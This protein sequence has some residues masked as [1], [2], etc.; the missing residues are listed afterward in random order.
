MSSLA[1]DDATGNGTV[2]REVVRTRPLLP[3]LHQIIVDAPP[4]VLRLKW[5]VDLIQRRSFAICEYRLINPTPFNRRN[6]RR[7][8]DKVVEPE[9]HAKKGPLSLRVCI[10]VICH[11]V[12]YAHRG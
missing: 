6:F 10:Q 1:Q 5:T 7:I 8:C 4:P 2:E 12:T 11:T 9:G 3:D